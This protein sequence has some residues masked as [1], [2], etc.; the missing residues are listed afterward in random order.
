MQCTNNLKQMGLGL[1]NY[2]SA[3]GSFPPDMILV[4]HHTS[5]NWLFE[6]TRSPA[7]RIAPIMEMGPLYNSINFSSTY[8]DSSNTTISY[9][10][11]KF[12]LCRSDPGPSIDNPSY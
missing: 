6:S 5:K 10:P 3:N 12:L 7:A 8:S 2:E 9:T 11:V 4:P 1:M